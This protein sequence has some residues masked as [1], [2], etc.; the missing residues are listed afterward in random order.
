MF[1]FTVW[2]FLL[3]KGILSVLFPSIVQG[4]TAVP[5]SEWI[6]ILTFECVNKWLNGSCHDP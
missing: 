2:I 4:P 3:G 6:L 1:L 5:D